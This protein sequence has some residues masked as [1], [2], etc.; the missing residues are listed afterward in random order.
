MVTPAYAEVA[1]VNKT[2]SDLMQYL[3]C[4]GHA[5]YFHAAFSTIQ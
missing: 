1:H 5:Y 3:W 2:Y 4:T